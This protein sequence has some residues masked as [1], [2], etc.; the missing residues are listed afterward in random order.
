M[1]KAA[2]LIRCAAPLQ[3]WGDSHRHTILTT[4]MEPTKSAITGVVCFAIGRELTEDVS[5]LAALSMTVRVDREG[6]VMRDFHVVR[7]VPRAG[8]SDGEVVRKARKRRARLDIHDDPGDSALLVEHRPTVVTYRHYVQDAHFLVALEGDLALLERIERGL[9]AP[10]RIV[11]L[12]RRA[13]LP[14][15]PMWVKGGLARDKTGEE[16]LSKWPWERPRHGVSSLRLV[17][18]L[19]RGDGRGELRQDWPVSLHPEHRRFGSYRVETTWV[20][21]NGLDKA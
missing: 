6:S 8:E 18:E 15:R 2:L 4:R 11:S 5:D 1:S 10:A 20:D 7:G 9:L 3:S 12:G 17:R 14:G 19:G 13:C 16:L 21:T